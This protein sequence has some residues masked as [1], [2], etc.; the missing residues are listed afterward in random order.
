MGQTENKDQ[1]AHFISENDD[2]S[3]KSHLDIVFELL[4]ESVVNSSWSAKLN[5][6]L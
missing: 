3:I 6:L 5:Y 4:P 2:D 1:P